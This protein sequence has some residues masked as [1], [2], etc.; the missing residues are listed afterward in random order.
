MN[1]RRRRLLAERGLDPDQVYREASVE[2]NVGLAPS[3]AP[4][5]ADVS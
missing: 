4:I 1:L 5:K 2:I 3:A